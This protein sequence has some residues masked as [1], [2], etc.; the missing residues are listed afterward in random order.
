MNLRTDQRRYKVFVDESYYAENEAGKSSELWRYYEIHGAYGIIY[1][2]SR[3]KLGMFIKSNT[4]ANRIN[5]PEW[6]IIQNGQE[7]RVYLLPNED[8]DKAAK[9]IKA[10][11][12]RQFTPEQLEMQKIRMEKARLGLNK[13]IRGA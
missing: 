4:I 5:E 10:R 9:M 13:S 11:K 2:N 7:E 8:L 3:S 12:K 6:K 1:S